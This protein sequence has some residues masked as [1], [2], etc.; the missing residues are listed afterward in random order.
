MTNGS[1][2]LH[3]PEADARIN[4]GLVPSRLNP[5][6]QT[7]GQ[8][9]STQVMNITGAHLYNQQTYK[10]IKSETGKCNRALYPPARVL[11]LPYVDFYVGLFL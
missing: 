5:T 8:R 7:A 3:R 6:Q 4:R 9:E 2:S 11:P 10:R 1:P